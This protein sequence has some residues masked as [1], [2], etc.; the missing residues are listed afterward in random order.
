MRRAYDDRRIIQLTTAQG[1]YV[2]ENIPTSDQRVKD[3]RFFMG[4]NVWPPE[5][6]LSSKDL[7]EPAEAYHT[8]LLK[9]AI[10][11]LDMIARSLPYGNNVFDKIVSNNPVAP[12]RML[13]YPKS[14]KTEQRQLG[15]S[16]HTDFGAITLLLQDPNPGLEVLDPQKGEWVPVMPNTDAY[17]VNIGDM[18]TKLTRGEYKSSWHRVLNKNP[19]DR[20]SIVFFFEG[21]LDCPLS[22]LDGTPVDGRTLTVEEHMIKRMTESYGKGEKSDELAKVKETDGMAEGN[23]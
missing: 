21:N 8:V 1:Y 2:G 12:L 15:A 11:V 7:K 14:Q 22:P 16:A 20:Y 6:L 10:V 5:S 23:A 17:V 13:H 4:S 3:C 18:L 9:L 19:G